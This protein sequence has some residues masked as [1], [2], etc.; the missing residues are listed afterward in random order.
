MIFLCGFFGMYGFAF[1]WLFL[2]I[3]LCTLKSFGI[4]YMMPFAA[5]T[6]DGITPV[7]DGILRAPAGRM[8]RR[9]VYTRA[10]QQESAWDGKSRKTKKEGDEKRVFSDN[11]KISCGR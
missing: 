3:H 10:R 4:P 8:D 9:P 6:E 5:T 2:L 1:G 11:H 7:T